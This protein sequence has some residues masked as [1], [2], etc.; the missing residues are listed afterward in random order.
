MGRG[1]L[2]PR[3]Q[4]R[5]S[6]RDQTARDP[7]PHS[8]R[9][10]AGASVGC[11][12][13]AGL[14]A[15]IY[16]RVPAASP[17]R[18]ACSSHQRGQ[19]HVLAARGVTRAR[20]LGPPFSGWVAAWGPP[21]RGGPSRALVWVRVQSWRPVQGGGYTGLQEAL[22][23]FQGRP[24]SCIIDGWSAG[25]H[26]RALGIVSKNPQDHLRSIFLPPLELE[27]GQITFQQI[28]CS[29]GGG[30]PLGGGRGLVGDSRGPGPP[31]PHPATSLQLHRGLLWRSE[32]RHTVQ[33]VEK[34]H[35]GSGVISVPGEP[36]SRFW[37]LQTARP[38]AH[39]PPAMWPPGLSLIHC[40]VGRV[41]PLFPRRLERRCLS[42]NVVCRVVSRRR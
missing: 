21:A 13:D 25:C 10:D 11:M 17:L 19:G 14:S 2:R 37:G 24:A 3:V 9:R 34:V 23:L 29:R 41:S 8:G 32:A 40:K 28:H 18:S 20:A 42:A 7:Q 12:V 26:R 31:T 39:H 27:S 33:P 36:G 22:L 16:T 35:C 30:V 4:H 15:L 5:G 1:G 38:Q 6:G